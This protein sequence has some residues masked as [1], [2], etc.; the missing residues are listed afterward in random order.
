MKR[1]K[2]IRI[3]VLYI[4]NCKKRAEQFFCHFKKSFFVLHNGW[5]KNDLIIW[6]HKR[7]ICLVSCS[8]RAYIY[9][10]RY[11]IMCQGYI[12]TYI[13]ILFYGCPGQKR[14]SVFFIHTFF[15]SIGNRLQF[16]LA[17]TYLLL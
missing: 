2:Y 6:S 7:F 4:A 10:Y 5:R 15:L 12:H 3:Y 9:I 17:Q 8:H 16:F 11:V 13:R 14:Y 1:I